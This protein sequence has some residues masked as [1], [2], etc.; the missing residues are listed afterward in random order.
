MGQDRHNRRTAAVHR[1][2]TTEVRDVER[3]LH[4]HRTVVHVPEKT[5]GVTN[6]KFRRGAA[7]AAGLS[8]ALLTFAYEPL[9]MTS[10][11]PVIGTVQGILGVLIMPGVLGSTVVTWNPHNIA[12]WPA[13]II[14]AFFYFGVTQL[15][16]SI[17]ARVASG[18]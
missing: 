3:R 11:N 9:S 8:L 6:K 12:W 4:Q 7:V 5:M 1:R 16:L 18:D 17:A 10:D 13:V 2:A 14:N 15:V